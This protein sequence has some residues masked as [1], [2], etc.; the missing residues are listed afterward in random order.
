MKSNQERSNGCLPPKK[1]EIL[2]LEQRP[3]VVAAPPAAVM[4]DSPHTENLAWLASVASERCRSRDAESPRCTISSTS[5]SS[6]ATSIYSSAAPL[7]AVPLTSLPAVYPTA[8]PQQ[9]G[10]IQFA[11]LGPNVQFISSGP[12][13]G[14]ISSHI[15]SANASSAHNSSTIG[16]R[17]ISMVTH[18][19]HLPQQQR[20]AAVSN[21]PFSLRTDSGVTSELSPGHHPVHFIWTAEHL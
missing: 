11:Q 7:S 1:R 3:V 18:C 12:Y 2:A 14:Y 15:I 20:G 5:S 9:A 13:A 19:S 6:P 8:M 21:R 16:Q 10:T 4:A 17:S